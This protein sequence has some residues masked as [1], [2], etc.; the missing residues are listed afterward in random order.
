VTTIPQSPCGSKARI[1][2]NT[3]VAAAEDNP[4]VAFP[5]G[6][7]VWLTAGMLCPHC[8]RRL[9][10]ADV[11]AAFGD[12]TLICTGCHHDVLTIRTKW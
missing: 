12:F 8:K 9:R 10:A 11:N 2:N 5:A 1:L 4:S 7:R 6:I 3:E